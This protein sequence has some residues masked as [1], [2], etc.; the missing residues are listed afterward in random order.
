[1]HATISR[2]DSPLSLAPREQIEHVTRAGMTL[3]DA[4]K[5]DD[6]PVIVSR[7]GDWILREHWGDEIRDGDVICV[8]HLPLGGGGGSNPL[9]MSSLR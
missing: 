5:E 4:A 2:S 9:V 6:R 8:V 7:N 1:M 3:R